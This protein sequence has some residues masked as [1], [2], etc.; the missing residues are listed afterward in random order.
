MFLC[1]LNF[2][3]HFRLI[4]KRAFRLVETFFFQKP[5]PDYIRFFSGEGIV[6]SEKLFRDCEHGEKRVFSITVENKGAQALTFSMLDFPYLF[7]G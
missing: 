7:A 5:A 4:L 3:L 2:L 1:F 6:E